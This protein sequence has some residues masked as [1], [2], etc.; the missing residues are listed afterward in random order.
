[1][2]GVLEDV[3]F[4]LNLNMNYLIPVVMDDINEVPSNP[5][6]ETY[7]FALRILKTVNH[8]TKQVQFEVKSQ[9]RGLSD[10]EVIV[11]VEEWLK[12][13]RGGF[14]AKAFGNSQPTLESK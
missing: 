1:M 6:E 13:V 9:N 8:K 12:K 5:D 7:V 10:P 2:L 11:F 14:A 4:G 3:S